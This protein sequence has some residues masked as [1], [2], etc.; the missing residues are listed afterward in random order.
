M[1]SHVTIE[2]CSL[3]KPQIDE[4]IERKEGNVTRHEM[5]K[6]LLIAPNQDTVAF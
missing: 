5:E 4:E 1:N 3:T 6:V 2:F